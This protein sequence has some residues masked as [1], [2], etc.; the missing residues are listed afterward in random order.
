MPS[1]EDWQDY[2]GPAAAPSDKGEARASDTAIVSGRPTITIRPRSAYK[3]VEDWENYDPAKAP[4]PA[5]PMT[6]GEAFGRGAI[7]AATFG[8]APAIMGAA[9]AGAQGEQLPMVGDFPGLEIVAQGAQRLT[10]EALQQPTLSTLITGAQRP[11]HEAYEKTRAAEAEA[12]SQAFE[13]HPGYAL[14]GELVG[15][16]VTPS[17]GV[18]TAGTLPARLGSGFVA[19]ATGGALY[20][21]GSAIGEGGSA[22]EAFRGAAEGVALG[23]PFGAA[24]KGAFGPRIIDPALAWARQTAAELGGAPRGLLS[25]L[26]GVP[27]L[28]SSLSSV[29]LAGYK[30]IGNVQKLQEKAG[31]RIGDIAASM[32]PAGRDVADDAVRRGLKSAIDVN[33]Q[34]AGAHYNAVDALIHPST[35]IDLRQ[36]ASAVQQVINRRIAKRQLDPEAGLE[37]VLNAIRHPQ[38]ISMQGARGLRSDIRDAG[39]L[40][41]HP[42]LNAGDY[43]RIAD[44]IGGDM[45]FAAHQHGA[46]KEFEAADKRFGEIAA[47]NTV[48][49][50]IL[51]SGGQAAIDK[52]TGAAR[53]GQGGAVRLLE[54]LKNTMPAADFQAIGGAILHALGEAPASG[55]FSLDKFVTGWNKLSPNAKQAL[56]SPAHLENINDIVHMGQVLKG[57]LATANKS[58]TAQ[59]LIIYEVATQAAEVAMGVGAGLIN[60]AYALYA[61]AS[62]V[63]LNL[64]T[65]W[66]ASPSKAAAMGVWSKALQAVMA[67]ATPT[68]TATFNIATRNLAHRLGVPVDNIIHAVTRATTADQQQNNNTVTLHP[69][70]HNPY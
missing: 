1:I 32:T 25:S 50:R 29:P 7:D 11:A 47:K 19:G 2:E 12:R 15:S 39:D 46:G 56:F 69:V 51:K 34:E 26:P 66:L 20:G 70:E 53:A 45:R 68:R 13:Q 63:G 23:G 60:P 3:S 8:T 9:A 62:A 16:L 24:F 41:P 65:R 5:R 58:H 38:Q 48:L 40:S 30:I 64:F 18:G 49:N 59:A 52:L 10:R 61:G 57:A 44:A 27:Q 37:Q 42:G 17:F 22:P 21:A 28:T 4:P 33:K 43:N 54:G 67:D 36:T 14:G 35:P 6:A 31:E 55:D